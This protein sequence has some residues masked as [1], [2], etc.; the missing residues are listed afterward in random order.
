MGVREVL[1]RNA[2]VFQTPATTHI[3]S[4]SASFST[5]TLFDSPTIA[6]SSG[7]GSKVLVNPKTPSYCHSVIALK[8]FYTWQPTINEHS[9][10]VNACDFDKARRLERKWAEFMMLGEEAAQ[11]G[12][13]RRRRMRE[14][15][16]A[17][18][19]EEGVDGAGVAIRRRRAR[20]SPLNGGNSCTVM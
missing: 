5:S 6:Y 3:N 4:T 10:R 20:S 19:G 14:A 11:G 18:A 16:E 9:K 8:A 7:T 1:S 2:D 17:M 12:R 13:R 15:L